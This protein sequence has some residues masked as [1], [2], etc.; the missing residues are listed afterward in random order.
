M[1]LRSRPIPKVLCAVTASAAL[2]AVEPPSQAAATPAAAA[3]ITDQC[4]ALYVWQFTTGGVRIHQY[5]GTGSAGGAVYGLGYTGQQFTAT[6]WRTASGSGYTWFY[7][8]DRSTGVS[9]WAA[10]AYLNYIG[11]EGVCLN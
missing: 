8:T 11:N 7:G 1:T 6:Q 10:T 3:T 9:G 5:P 2:L 4:F